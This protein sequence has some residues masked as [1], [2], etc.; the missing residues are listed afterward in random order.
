MPARTKHKVYAVRRGTSPGIFDNWAD[1]FKSVQ[2]YSGAEYKGFATR[3]QA[4]T[5]LNS[6]VAPVPQSRPLYQS[7]AHTVESKLEDAPDVIATLLDVARAQGHA[8]MM[9]VI[10]TDGSALQNGKPGAR[11]GVGVW[12]GPDCKLNL[13]KRLNPSV[14]K[15]SNNVAEIIAACWALTLC[16]VYTHPITLRTD[17]KYT[18]NCVTS[19][20]EGWRSKGWVTTS[21]TPVANREH[22]EMLDAL[23]RARPSAGPVKFEWVK[24][25]SGDEGNRGADELAVRGA[26]KDS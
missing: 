2:H 3:A 19:W 6:N 22:V 4:E 14:Y 24:G 8:N 26:R 7:F 16:T 21:G 5:W 20:L 15:Q 13:S 23:I 12:F 1:T 17:S 10:N 9:L 25:H 11:A 18:M